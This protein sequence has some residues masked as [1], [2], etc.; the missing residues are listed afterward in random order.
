LE[1]ELVFYGKVFGFRPAGD[2]PEL[3]VDNLD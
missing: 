1:T 3:H 2:L